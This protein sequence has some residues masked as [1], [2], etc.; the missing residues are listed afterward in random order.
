[1]PF[2][3]AEFSAT[4]HTKG[5]SD[6]CLRWLS[7]AEIFR[8]A[9]K[10]PR[11]KMSFRFTSTPEIFHFLAEKVYRARSLHFD[12]TS[13]I[14]F[15]SI[16]RQRN[17]IIFLIY[18]IAGFLHFKYAARRCTRCSGK[19]PFGR[20]RNDVIRG[21]HSEQTTRDGKIREDS[22]L[23]EQREE[24][25]AEHSGD[26]SQTEAEKGKFSLDSARLSLAKHSPSDSHFQHFFPSTTVSTES[27]VRKSRQKKNSDEGCNE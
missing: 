26:S 12:L 22:R 18:A 4:K 7:F 9:R 17:S 11:R 1:M 14:A 6:S 20:A 3:S 5:A 21:K 2:F 24:F 15:S 10:F 23:N 25:P 8:S 13:T 16:K 27:S 19:N